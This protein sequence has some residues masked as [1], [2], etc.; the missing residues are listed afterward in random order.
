MEAQSLGIAEEMVAEFNVWVKGLIDENTQVSRPRDV[1]QLESRIYQEGR[2]ILGRLFSG[3]LQMAADRNQENTRQCPDCGRRRRHKGTRSRNLISRVGEIQL[4]GPYWYCPECGTGAHSADTVAPDSLTETMRELV[5]LLGTSMGSFKK[6]SCVLDR[7]LDVSL[8]DNTIRRICYKRGRE[9]ISASFEP[10]AVPRDSDVIGSCDGTSVNTR[11]DGWRELKAYQYRY[12]EF[13]YGKA[14]LTNSVVF[15][16]ELRRG[17]ID[18]NASSCQRLFFL[19]DAASWIDK[20][21]SVQLPMA[22]HIIDIWHAY[23]HIWEAGRKIHGEG[24][25][26]ARRWSER[27]NAVLAKQGGR[28]LR[29]RLKKLQYGDPEKQAALEALIGYLGRN[30]TRMQYDVYAEKGYPISSGPMES[31]CKQ[32]GVRL[33]GPGMR[34]SLPNI[35]PMAALVSAWATDNWQKLWNSAA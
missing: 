5:C 17:A 30:W 35:D 19:S 13:R 3:L 12:A 28:S 16:R 23:E 27:Y 2:M 8:S 11:Q 34:W 7:L 32:L 21:V 33:K 1:T 29:S 25:D 20:I 4:K 10:D 14:F 22:I 9:A 18:I 31:F 24:T 6:A 15:G 26:Q